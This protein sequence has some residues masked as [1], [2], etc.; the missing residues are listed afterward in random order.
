[1]EHSQRIDAAEVEAALER[2]SGAIVERHR[3]HAGLVLAGIANGGV[4]FAQL[5][6]ERIGPALGREI[7]CGV[8]NIA[9]HRD[10]IGRQPIPNAGE[11]TELPFESEGATVILA[12]DVIFSGRTARAAINEIFDL[13]RPA[14]LELAVLVD[15]GGRRLPIAPDY[16]GMLVEASGPQRVSVCLDRNDANGLHIAIGEE[17]R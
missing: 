12:D 10:D 7:P 14:R 11:P 9:F 17:A 16:T 1:M 4:A 5:L 15:R 6:A 3:Q 8:V 13:G 2:V